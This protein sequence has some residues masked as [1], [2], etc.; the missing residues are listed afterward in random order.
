M[1]LSTV[2]CHHCGMEF[3]RP[4]KEVTRSLKLGRPQFCT[5]SHATMY[6]ESL[7]PEGLSTTSTRRRARK[8][9]IERN[10]KE[11]VCHCGKPA[12]VHHKDGNPTNNDPSNHDT[13]CRSHHISLENSLFPKRKKYALYEVDCQTNKTGL[14]YARRST[15]FSTA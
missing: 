4:T 1:K 6:F 9:W 8:I 2:T 15:K 7:R 12:D 14:S 13:L 11:P 3:E 5:Q 10:D